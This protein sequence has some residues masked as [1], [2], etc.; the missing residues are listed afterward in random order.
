MR[1][2]LCTSGGAGGGGGGGGG[3]GVGQGQLLLS[4]H[5]LFTWNFNTFLEVAIPRD[6]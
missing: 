4:R 2:S 6:M 5:F 3:G 1:I